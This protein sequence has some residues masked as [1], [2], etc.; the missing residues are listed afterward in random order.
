MRGFG[1]K[2]DLETGVPQKWYIDKNGVKRWHDDDSIAVRALPFDV[3]RCNGVGDDVDGWREGCDV[4]FRRLS[5]GD[6]TRQV[7]MQPPKIIAFE[8][9]Y[10]ISA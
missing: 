1:M 2:I 10:L 3:A 7:Y 9:E 6:D 5:P 4:C 8:C